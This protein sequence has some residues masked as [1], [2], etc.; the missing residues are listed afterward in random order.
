MGIAQRMHDTIEDWQAEWKERL[1][2]WLADV[3]L[4]VLTKFLDAIEDETRDE[5]TEPLEKLKSIPNLPPEFRTFI[6]RAT[7]KAMPQAVVAIIPYLVG[8]M[9]GLAMG[10]AAPIARWSGYF[11]DKFV[12]SARLDPL[13]AIRAYWREFISED[14]LQE[15][16]AEQG[17][18]DEDIK[19]L[20]NVSHF[21]PAPADLVHWQAREVFEESM[22][23]RYGLDDEFEAIAKEPF[24]KAG[25]TEEQIRNFWRAHWEHASWIQVVEM[26]RR[27]QLTEEEIKDWFRLVEI[28]PF[29]REK[30][31]NISYAVPT[32]VDVR[33]WW[34]MRTID[35]DRLRE[36]YAWQGYHGKDL[37]DYV[38]WTKV[39]VAFPDLISRFKNGWITEEDVRSELTALGMPD[40]RVQE[41]IET[42]IKAVAPERVEEGRNLAKGDIIKGVK[43]GVIEV[44][45]GMELLQDI[46]FDEDEAQFIFDINI[47]PVEDI[48]TIIKERNL[49]K[50]DILNAIKKDVLSIND[51]R[52]MLL[53][54]G[55]DSQ[56][57]DILILVK[58]GLTTPE[59]APTL[60]ASASPSTYAGFK[61]VTQQYR[62]TLGLS[63]S[64]IPKE[65]VAANKILRDAKADLAE[66]RERKVKESELAPYLKAVSD[67][68]YGYRQLYITWNEQRKKG[69]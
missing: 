8:G 68:E 47:A 62:K 43:K 1:A 60:A 23:E 53:G 38:L 66:A 51:G 33:R 29:W 61:R 16:L 57:A 52:N 65:L 3:T 67:A 11:V 4:Q 6:D 41:M 36:V 46:G 45:E 24:F 18:S 59:T 21:Y 26:L 55:Y 34:D 64:E 20:Q 17:W 15:I 35:E 37:D 56:E 22:V 32:R 12:R 48:P 44:A 69:S 10:S 5:A 39:Y 7:S 40:D 49:T 27:G 63:Y 54:L 14:Y 25:M 58:L 28:P 30:L 42:K 31:I 50:A 13:T 2:N 19:T 9:I